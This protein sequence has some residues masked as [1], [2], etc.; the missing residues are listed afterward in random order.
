MIS[1]LLL[2]KIAQ[3]FLGLVLGFILV[4]S[5]KAKAADSRHLS[6]VIL[7][8]INP[9]VIIGAYQVDFSGDMVN[10][11]LL[12]F[13]AAI[14]I[15]LLFFGLTAALRRP[16]RLNAVE[17]AS[18]IYSNCVNL[19]IP[20]VLSILGKEYII[21]TSM[22]IMVQV[23]CLWSHCRML[24]SGERTIS[25]R[26]IFGNLNVISTLIGLALF[27]LRIQIPAV[28]AEA[29]DS[30][31]VTLGPLNMVVIGMLLGGADLKKIVRI[32]GVWKVTAL[33][34][35]GYPLV[36]LVL[37][38]CSGLAGLVPEGEKLLLLSLLAACAPSGTMVTSIAQVYGGD[39]EYASAI[40][41]VSTVL[42]IATMPFIIFLYQL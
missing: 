32:G 14:A 31:A 39:A 3:M 4:R 12:S 16:L 18:A 10:S 27:L 40:S 8:V 9:C 13:G 28:L 5:G 41:M 11:L 22:Y 36:V 42:C 37:L 29:M 24:L 23:F 25:F 20:I 26:N 34:L 19:L 15:H 35:L 21:F 1:L 33:R 2:R 30:I 38:K 6:V 17:Q 7:Y